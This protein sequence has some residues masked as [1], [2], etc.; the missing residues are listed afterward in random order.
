MPTTSACHWGLWIFENTSSEHSVVDI[1]TW[2]LLSNLW[3]LTGYYLVRV[4]RKKK[5]KTNQGNG[6]QI[7]VLVTLKCCIGVVVRRA[8][9]RDATSYCVGGRG[10]ARGGRA[11]SRRRTRRGRW[12]SDAAS[13]GRTSPATAPRRQRRRTRRAAAARRPPPRPRGRLARRHTALA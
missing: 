4:H 13:R 11:G 7:K 5:K 1:G 8:G 2:R 9:A 12:P 10:E 3:G 6:E